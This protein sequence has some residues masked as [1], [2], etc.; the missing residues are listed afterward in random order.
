MLPDS[1]DARSVEDGRRFAQRLYLPRVIG[2]AL[3]FVCIA[4][5]L[6]EQGAPS[7]LF[8]LLAVNLF[9]AP[10]LAYWGALRS[11]DPYRAELR[12]LTLD[13][14]Y[15]GIWIAALHFSLAPSVVLVAMLAMDK[16]AVGG[17]KFLAR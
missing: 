17:P 7:W 5:G 10:H 12:N 13:S 2:L 16:A 9:A 15:G 1:A 3:G 14:V 4:G 6:W 11:R 8:A